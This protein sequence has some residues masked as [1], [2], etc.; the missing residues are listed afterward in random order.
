MICQPRVFRAAASLFLSYK[1]ATMPKILPETGVGCVEKPLPLLRY[2]FLS[3]TPLRGSY[4]VKMYFTNYILTGDLFTMA[5]SG[6]VIKYH[7][8]EIFADPRLPEGVVVLVDRR[9]VQPIYIPMPLW[10]NE[11]MS[12]VI[13]DEFY[14]PWAYD[15]STDEIIAWLKGLL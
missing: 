14:G 8:T 4:E 9:H 13:T 7:D 12:M 1:A 2:G 6:E 10:Y 3:K 11:L 15:I 5:P